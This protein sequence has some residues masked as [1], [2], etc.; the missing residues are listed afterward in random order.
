MATT[1]R[2]GGVP[3]AG[4]SFGATQRQRLRH[5]V[6]PLNTWSFLAATYDGAALR[7]Y[8]NGTLAATQTQTGAITTST[9]Q[10]QI[11]SDSI[12]GQYFNGLID[13]IRIY[14]TPLTPPHSKPT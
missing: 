14:N 7:F 5:A 2:T 1:D 11:G 10:L 13:Q 12:W 8:V 6:L 3:A 9:N 4:G